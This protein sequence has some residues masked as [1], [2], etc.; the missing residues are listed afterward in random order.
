MTHAKL[1]YWMPVSE[2][3]P[4]NSRRRRSD[5]PVR[6]ADPARP[7]CPEGPRAARAARGDRV[8]AVH[9]GLPWIAADIRRRPTARWTRRRRPDHSRPSTAREVRSG[10][11]RSDVCCPLPAARCPR[12]PSDRGRDPRAALGGAPYGDALGD[13][14]L[15]LLDVAH[16]AD[17]PSAGGQACELPMTSSS[18]SGSSVRTPRR[19]TGCRAR[20]RRP[21]PARR[22][23]ARVPGRATVKVSPPDRLPGRAGCRWC[24]RGRPA[25]GRSGG[26]VTRPRARRTSRG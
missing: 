13:A 22:R 5:L 12:G 3:T 26:P 4:R 10:G 17:L 2:G 15:E 18:V 8:R 14:L 25:R 1:D 9:V 7:C 23:R 21:R 24:G 6:L 20:P 11:L 16:D 19:R